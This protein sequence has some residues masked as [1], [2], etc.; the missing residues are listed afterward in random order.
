MPI[1]EHYHVLKIYFVI[2]FCPRPH[3]LTDQSTLKQ[4]HGRILVGTIQTGILSIYVRA[5]E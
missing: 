1:M 5:R 2:P 4:H 3:S